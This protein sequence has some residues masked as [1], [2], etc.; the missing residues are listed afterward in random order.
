MSRT[1]RRTSGKRSWMKM[2]PQFEYE[3]G[4]VQRY[5]CIN[6]VEWWNSP[7]NWFGQ[8]KIERKYGVHWVQVLYRVPVGLKDIDREYKAKVERDWG[9]WS[10]AGKYKEAVNERDRAH[11]RAELHK[12]KESCYN[13]FDDIYEYDDSYENSTQRSLIWDIF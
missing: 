12:I 9:N 8:R 2:E 5:G 7:T 13:G 3:R 10:A 4:W 11:R 1:I 6:Y